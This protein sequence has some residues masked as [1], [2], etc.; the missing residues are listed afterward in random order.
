MDNLLDD[1]DDIA[2]NDDLFIDNGEQEIEQEQVW[3]VIDEYFRKKGLVGQQLDS[4]DD[5]IKNTIQ[6]LVYDSGELVVTPENQYM[7]GDDIE[8]VGFDAALQLNN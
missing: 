2:L 7:P 5:F 1:V 6:E 8:Q 3:I 4:F